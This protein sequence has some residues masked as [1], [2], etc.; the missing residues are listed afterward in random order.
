MEEQIALTMPINS[1]YL[2]LFNLEITRLH[3]MGLIERW[4]KEY[5]PQ[6]DRCSK[7]SSVIEVINH[8]VTMDDMQGCFLVLVFGF[9]GGFTFIL[10]ECIW[11]YYGRYRQSR[12]NKAIE[13]FV[14]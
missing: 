5:L 7:Q 14:K 2:E 9:L 3:Q 1:P 6:K 11:R 4:I 10:F 8:Q 12:A 13:P